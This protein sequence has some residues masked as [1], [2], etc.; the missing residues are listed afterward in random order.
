MLSFLTERAKEEK[1]R[2]RALKQKQKLNEYYARVK[3]DLA[4]IQQMN[5]MGLSPEDVVR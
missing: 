4:N 1:R 3:S 2:Q 5:E